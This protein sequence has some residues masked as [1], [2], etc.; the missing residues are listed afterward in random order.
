MCVCVGGGGVASTV[1]IDL[2]YKF[3]QVFGNA[4]GF[5]AG[6]FLT[7]LLYF[8]LVFISGYDVKLSMSVAIG[9][10]KLS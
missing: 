10:G 2:I 1:Q 8:V 4:L 3:V 7:I 6:V 9:V 5:F